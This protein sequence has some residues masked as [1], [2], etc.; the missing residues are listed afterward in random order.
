MSK[1][2]AA[3]QGMSRTKSSAMQSSKSASK[4]GSVAAVGSSALSQKMMDSIINDIKTKYT[5]EHIVGMSQNK[6]QAEIATRLKSAS[7]K[8]PAKSRTAAATKM[9]ASHTITNLEGSNIQVIEYE[10]VEDDRTEGMD[11]S[12][13]KQE[14]LPMETVKKST[15]KSAKK[16]LS[17][18][19]S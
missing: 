10:Q 15:R 8:K 19:K 3:S 12:D 14:Q 13:Y 1:K 6:L 4:M 5:K 18:V 11:Y 7:K 16:K 2:T 9:P 17:P